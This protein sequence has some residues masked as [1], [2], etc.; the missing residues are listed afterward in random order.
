MKLLQKCRSWLKRPK[1]LS[2]SIGTKLLLIQPGSFQMG[3]TAGDSD[4]QPVHCVTL[5]YPFWMGK[6]PVTNRQ[7]ELFDPTHREFRGQKG[8]ASRDD[9]PV[10]F[11]SWHDAVKFCKWLSQKEGKTYRLPT[12]AEWEY[13]CRAG[14]L[15]PYFTGKTLPKTYLRAQGVQP[16]HRLISLKVGTTPA[17]AWGLQDMHGIVEEW[18]EDW[19]GPYESGSQKNPLG[20]MDGLFKVT[21][22]GSHNTPVEYLRSA[23]RSGALPEDK[24]WLLGFRIVQ[25]ER[26]HT[27]PLPSLTTFAE[28]PSVSQKTWAWDSHSNKDPFFAPPGP[29]L[30][31]ANEFKNIPMF[32]HNHCPSITWCPNGDLLA[33]WFST[34]DEKSR[35]MVLMASRLHPGKTAWEKP[36]E[37][38][39]VPDR[40]MTGTSLF[41]HSDGTLFHLNGLSIADTW[42][43]LALLIRKSTDNGRTW[44]RPAFV[45]PHYQTHNQIIHGMIRTQEGLW[46]QPCDSVPKGDGG[47]SLQ[48][49]RDQGRTW[50][51]PQA[52]IKEPD[53]RKNGTGPFIAGI[54]ANLVQLKDGSFFALG[55]SG[56]ILDAVDHFDGKMPQSI[57]VDQGKSWKYV[58]SEFPSI[59]GGQRLALLRLQEGPILLLSF[60]DNYRLLK[61]GAPRGMLL[62]SQ[63]QKDRL[64]FGLFAALSLDEGKSWP[65]KK[66]LTDHS[67]R[68][69]PYANWR[70]QFTLDENHAEPRGYLAAVQS[71]EGR[72]HVVSSMLYYCFNYAW[73]L[74]SP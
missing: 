5:D 6:T 40:N 47:T 39:N 27:P 20:R 54:H 1:T 59:G 13:G 25:A 33:A 61:A 49:S 41:T 56:K 36:F 28:S 60:T 42:A 21:R 48:I 45:N 53:Y 11:V 3:D 62:K 31:P 71:P 43:Q 57:S 68:T 72:I 26:P 9:E 58:Q 24:H 67:G 4:E 35:K 66:L 44:S 16:E 50:Q 19:Y 70:Y 51:D 2:N 73:L 30:P 23:N 63:G 37:F 29:Y 22:G 10:L 14:T 69:L 55:R 46:I 74:K 32:D 52:G 65:I 12:E 18:C 64:A 15:T 17:N 38:L 34:P 8:F 7:Y